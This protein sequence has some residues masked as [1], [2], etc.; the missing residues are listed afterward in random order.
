VLDIMMLKSDGYEVGTVIRNNPR[1]CGIPI[2]VVSGLN[3]M[4]RSFAARVQVEGFLTKP[5]TAEVLIGTSTMILDKRKA[6]A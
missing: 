5:F 4:S 1:T 6:Q 2:L 3:K